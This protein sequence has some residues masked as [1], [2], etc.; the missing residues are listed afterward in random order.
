MFYE[1]LGE[2]AKTDDNQREALIGTMRSYYR[3]GNSGKTLEAVGKVLASQ[4]MSETVKIE[5]T[6]IRAISNFN[7]GNTTAATADFESTIKRIDNE[8]AAESKYHLALIAYQKK[9]Y[10]NAE[11][12]CFE[13]ISTYPSYA[14]WLIKTYILLSDVFV[15]QNMFFQAKATLQSILDNYEERDELYKEAETKYQ[16]VLALESGNSGVK[17]T[18]GAGFSEF[19]K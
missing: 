19:E 18:Q 7:S 10:K 15:E 8:W 16:K 13:F 14:K 12:L 17:S 9:E 4:G 6:F 3:S 5:A 11:K 1:A 2:V